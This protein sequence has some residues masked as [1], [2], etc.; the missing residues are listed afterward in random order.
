M[1]DQQDPREHV[2]SDCD[3]SADAEA[4]EQRELTQEEMHARY[5]EQLRRMSCPGCGEEPHVF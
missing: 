2:D 3:H 1:N 4:S 5:L